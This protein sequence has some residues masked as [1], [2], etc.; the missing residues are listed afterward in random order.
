MFH[1]RYLWA[2]LGLWA[3]VMDPV[4]INLLVLSKDLGSPS[5]VPP[6]VPFSL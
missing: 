3:L 4:V 1:R 5:P 6:T 2:R